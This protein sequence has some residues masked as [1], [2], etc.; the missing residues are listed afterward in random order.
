MCVCLIPILL[1]LLFFLI[2]SSD[3]MQ[4]ISETHS[5]LHKQD[6]ASKLSFFCSVLPAFIDLFGCFSLHVKRRKEKGW[7]GGAA[8]FI[9]IKSSLCAA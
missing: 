4:L 5:C 1:L 6:A 7:G 3:L 8:Y 2:A 9:V